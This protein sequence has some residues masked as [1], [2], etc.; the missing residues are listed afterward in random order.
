[1]AFIRHSSFGNSSFSAVRLGPAEMLRLF[2]RS[3]SYSNRFAVVLWTFVGDARFR[4]D[5]EIRAAIGATA[6]EDSADAGYVER[7]LVRDFGF[8][9]GVPV[10]GR[11][12][13]RDRH[14]PRGVAI[15]REK[16]FRGNGWL[17]K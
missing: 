17:R 13:D 1:M 5:R 3:I 4:G 10:C 16:L 14:M 11:A 8:D 12:V 2:E 7:E 9:L 15:L 6:A